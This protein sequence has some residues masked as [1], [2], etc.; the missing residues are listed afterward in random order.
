[1]AAYAF[2][3]AEVLFFPHVVDGGSPPLILQVIEQRAPEVEPYDEVRDAVRTWFVKDAALRQATTF[4]HKLQDAA[5]EN[6]LEEAVGTMDAR[7]K[8]L[9]G[10]RAAEEPMLSVQ[11]TGSFTRGARWIV[12]VEGEASTVADEAFALAGGAVGLAVAEAPVY[13]CYVLQVAEREAA[14][15]EGFSESDPRIRAAYVGYKQQSVLDGWLDGLLA[16]AEPDPRS[17]FW[18]EPEKQG[19]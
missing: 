5:A 16:A 12:G 7:L 19:E 2:D 17:S 9:L 13:K 10:N 14:A 11:E 3:E 15:T 4:S 6:G 18:K 1:V 8:D